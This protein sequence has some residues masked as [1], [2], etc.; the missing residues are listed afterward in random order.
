MA[1]LR[2]DQQ[3]A[4]EDVKR[5]MRWPSAE[6]I[7]KKLT[8]ETLVVWNRL[9]RDFFDELR[10]IASETNVTTGN[11]PSFQTLVSAKELEGE[12]AKDF[13]TSELAGIFQELA[14]LIGY[15]RAEKLRAVFRTYAPELFNTSDPLSLSTAVWNQN[16]PALIADGWEQALKNLEANGRAQGEMAR[17]ELAAAQ[18]VNSASAFVGRVYESG[19]RY[20]TSKVTIAAQAEAMNTILEGLRAGKPW[21]AIAIDLR[22]RI[23]TAYLYHWQRLVRTEMTFAYYET[24][25]ERYRGAGAQFVQLS[26]SAGACPVCVN[27]KGFYLLGTEPPIP[28]STHPNCRCVYT[29]FFRLPAGAQLRG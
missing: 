15:E 2:R 23:G 18:Q 16:Y 11:V 9:E 6:A 19:F 27:L 28:A 5:Q 8:R 4:V 13:S 3:R 26:T 10:G 7:A 22:Q 29:P 20:V 17:V 25:V 14:A 1:K 24:F 12:S 21:N